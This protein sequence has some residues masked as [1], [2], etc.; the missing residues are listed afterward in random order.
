MQNNIQSLER[1][2]T[3]KKYTLLGGF[4]AWLVR[5]G[6]VMG[7]YALATILMTYP[8][9]FNLGQNWLATFDN[10]TYVKLWDIFWL[11]RSQSTGQSLFFT[12]DLFYPSGLDLSFHSLSWSV[13]TVSWL[14]TPI[15]GI[16]DAYN[17]TILAAV[18][19]TAYAAYLLIKDSVRFRAAA[20][21]GGAVYSFAPYHVA[22]TGGHPD[23]VH[24]APVPLAVL[25]LSRALNRSHKRYAVF[26]AF[27]VGLAAMTSLYI[28][29]FTLLTLLPVFGFLAI[30]GSRWRDPQFW[31]TAVLFTFIASLLLLIR[32]FP[33]FRDLGSL[34]F[35]IESKYLADAGQTDLLSYLIPSPNH[36]FFNPY[37]NEIVSRFAMNKKWPAYVGLIPIFLTAAALTWK[38]NRTTIYLWF[39]IGLCFMILSLGTSLR[40]NGIIYEDVVMPATFLS[41]FPPIR[42]VARPDFFVLGMFLPLAVCAAFGLERWLNALQNHKVI[43][44]SLP[45]ILVTMLMFEYWNGPFKGTSPQVSPFYTFLADNDEP[46]AVIDLPFGRQAS[47]LYLYYQ[48]IHQKPIVEGLSARTPEG[49]Y[50]YINA[51]EL[52]LHW[53]H[54]TPLDCQ[55]MPV[56]SLQRDLTNLVNDGFRYIIV[57][58]KAGETI[59]SYEGYLTVEPFYEDKR[60]MVYSVEE[61]LNNPPCS[62]LGMAGVN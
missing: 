29:D 31:Q 41:W 52:L 50:S 16:I 62:S 58:Q 25:F 37:I 59:A 57:H 60:L 19:T 14:L 61:L 34:S 35:A 40:F 46:I 47:K 42:A 56:E 48:I 55:V 10:D 2:L 36:P 17:V 26:A 22:H 51:N 13:A 1:T 32:L 21:L 8:L 33:I 38:K 9:V 3:L 30:Q 5:D 23:L 49:A 7:L 12:N 15:L 53:K 28:M 20:W 54:K 4:K 27:M 43:Q 39:F 44:A 24:L 6:L 18:W 11:E 45:I